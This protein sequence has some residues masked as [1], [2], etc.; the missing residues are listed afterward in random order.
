MMYNLPTL[1]PTVPLTYEQE[2]LTM[3]GFLAN[4]CWLEDTL[5]QDYVDDSDV[6]LPEH[7]PIFSTKGNE[8]FAF[9][10]PEHVN[11]LVREGMV[12]VH[13]LTWEWNEVFGVRQNLRRFNIT[14]KG[15]RF[16]VDRQISNEGNHGD[17]NCL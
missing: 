4:G 12:A 2:K 16:V 1:Q 10:D 7:Q 6:V 17:G 15:R 14:D 13:L 3:L 5:P 8:K 11:G 9:P